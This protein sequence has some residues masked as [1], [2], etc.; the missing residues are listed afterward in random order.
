MKLNKTSYSPEFWLR[1]SFFPIQ[2]ETP[3]NPAKAPQK[4]HKNSTKTKRG[5]ANIGPAQSSVPMSIQ[6]CFD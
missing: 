1:P 5:E 4:L 3:Q 6:V 2:F